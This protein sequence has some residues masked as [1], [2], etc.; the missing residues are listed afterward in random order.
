MVTFSDFSSSIIRIFLALNGL[1]SNPKL[2]L[3]CARR[4]IKAILYILH[5]ATTTTAWFTP[6]NQAKVALNVG[7]GE[8]E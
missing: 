2:I 5:L 3:L 8:P 7:L 4:D 1:L 6:E